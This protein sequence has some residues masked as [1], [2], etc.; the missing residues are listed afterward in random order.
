M[1]GTS[2]S[3][4]FALLVILHLTV[5]EGQLTFS[6]GYIIEGQPITIFC[7]IPN[8]NGIAHWIKDDEQ[9]TATT[10]SNS[11][12][13]KVENEGTRYRYAS[14]VS[15]ISVT[16]SNIARNEERDWKCGHPGYDSTV[17]RIRYN[18]NVF[19]VSD[20]VVVDGLDR[21]VTLG[22]DIPTVTLTFT[23]GCMHPIPTV[24]VY[25]K[26]NTNASITSEIDYVNVTSTTC[27]APEA[28]YTG[29][30]TIYSDSTC[31]TTLFPRLLI[32][33]TGL[34]LEYTTTEWMSSHYI[35]FPTCKALGRLTTEE[36]YGYAVL[37]SLVGMV[38]GGI[39]ILVLYKILLN[40]GKLSL[41]VLESTHES[42]TKLK[43]YMTS[44]LITILLC[45]VIAG[46]VVVV[47]CGNTECSDVTI[48]RSAAFV[49]PGTLLQLLTV[50]MVV[51]MFVRCC[52]RD[53][54]GVKRMEDHTVEHYH[55]NQVYKQSENCVSSNDSK[56]RTFETSQQNAGRTLSEKSEDSLNLHSDRGFVN[57]TS[58]TNT[59]LPRSSHKV[60]E[61]SESEVSIDLKSDRSSV[62]KLQKDEQRKLEPLTSTPL[63]ES[64]SIGLNR[65][66][67]DSGYNSKNPG[68]ISS[69][70]NKDAVLLSGKNSIIAP[71]NQLSDK[72]EDYSNNSSSS[73]DESVKDGG[74]SP[75]LYR[76]DH[77]QNGFR[78]EVMRNTST[79]TTPGHVKNYQSSEQSKV[80]VIPDEHSSCIIS[81]PTGEGSSESSSEDNEVVLKDGE[82]SKGKTTTK[83][84]SKKKKWRKKKQPFVSPEQ[85]DNTEKIKVP[86][87][88]KTIKKKKAK[89][90]I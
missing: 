84:R 74:L 34:P 3:R 47:D 39:L 54:S 16:I 1:V 30:I 58:R 15:G 35:K 59:K 4:L 29:A 49:V 89:I 20:S 51:Y 27:T 19:V 53:K 82:K 38:I 10:C 88:K 25:S 81:V 68:S 22:D 56:T 48:G 66:Q 70:E 71:A 21:N 50:C 80:M 77:T 31:N 55:N 75:D 76:K 17:Y 85:T 7:R 42:S 60:K 14:N 36:A 61:N 33:P 63:K 2:S 18:E 45:F 44:A 6:T 72:K 41:F 90:I 24:G 11:G 9:F 83:K 52:S 87:K 73:S 78:P 67:G 32:T 65:K 26:Q 37:F 86:K 46:I 23:T 79:P 43:L 40:S 12:F 28:G 69:V 5:C 62:S 8:F 13:C 64:D 57:K